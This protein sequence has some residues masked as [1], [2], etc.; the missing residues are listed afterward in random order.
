MIKFML[1]NFNYP[2]SVADLFLLDSLVY[3]HINLK[4][5]QLYESAI[6]FSS[7]SDNE[8][9]QLMSKLVQLTCPFSWSNRKF[10]WQHKQHEVRFK[11]LHTTRSILVQTAG[12]FSFSLQIRV[13]TNFC[14]VFCSL[15]YKGHSPGPLQKWNILHVI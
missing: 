7:Q 10:L 3:I 1:V 8:R 6:Y 15:I 4:V 14:Q 12:V 9:W 5:H 2:C 11:C 13:I